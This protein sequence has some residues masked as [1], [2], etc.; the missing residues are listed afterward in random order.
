MP[1][2]PA[3]VRRLDG[4]LAAVPTVGIVDAE[5]G[6]VL[7][8][9]RVT[10]RQRW[11]DLLH[12]EAH[13]RYA[14]PAF[15]TLPDT[16]DQLSAAIT[17]AV[18]SHAGGQPAT[19]IVAEA[20]DTARLLGTISWRSTGPP[21][22][23]NVDLGY[24]VHPDSRG[25]GVATSAVRL[26][27]RWLTTAANGPEA[28]RVQLD[29]SV[30]NPASCK[31][32]ERAG[33]PREGMRRGYLPLWGPAADGGSR[34]HDVCLHGIPAVDVPP[35]RRHRAGA[36][37]IERGRVAVMRRVRKGVT[38]HVA[39]G[40]G[41]DVGESVEAAAARELREETGL[42][43]AVS[44]ADLFATLLFNDA[45]QYYHTIRSW[46][47]RF[48]TGDGAEFAAPAERKGTYE[49]VWVDLVDEAPDTVD[50]WRPREVRWLLAE[51]ERRRK[52]ARR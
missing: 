10:D 29:H 3:D 39:F 12:D 35:P 27:L 36:L 31:A 28:G 37:P 18:E 17:E 43:A 5:H 9:P 26:L 21:S 33:L 2:P 32:A 46:R 16:P 41:V 23:R 11:F 49:P 38:Y 44:P 15:L 30:E 48:G 19:F 7:R 24:A 6:I 1:F 40:G 8:P 47:G 51:A 4:T 34:R 50:D 42:T 22:M 52:T 13:V 25:R 20:S 14:T 45:W